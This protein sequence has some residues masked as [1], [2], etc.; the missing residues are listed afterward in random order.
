MRRLLAATAAYFAL[1]CYVAAPIAG[2]RP[3]VGSRVAIDLTDSGT[4]VM[5]SQL[6]PG[7]V[8]LVGNIVGATDSALVLAVRTVTNRRG[9]EETWTGE[10]VTVPSA[11]I[12]TMGEQR[13]SVGRSVGLALAIAVA[14]ALAGK[15][16]SGGGSG[17]PPPTDGGVQ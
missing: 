7:Q 1:G 10:Q 5:A 2:A 14:A 6:G 12:A 9:I 15:L 3:A 16:M 8:R 17:S 11:V 13:V 4:T